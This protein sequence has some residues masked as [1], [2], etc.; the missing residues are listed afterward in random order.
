MAM[1]HLHKNPETAA[2]TIRI[3]VCDD[4]PLITEGLQS[5]IE[6]KKGFDVVA[7]ASSAASL[8][9]VLKIAEAD[10]LLLDINL[11]DGNGIDLCKDLKKQYP[12]LR[13]IGLSNFN[14]RSVI[15]RMIANGASGYLVKSSSLD[16]LLH[17]IEEVYAGNV[18]FGKEA[19]NILASL[20]SDTVQEL[21]PVTRREKEVLKWL[22]Q[23]LTSAEIGGKMFISPQTVDSHRKSLMQKFDVNK[24]VNLIQEAKRLGFV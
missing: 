24:T 11:P 14:E 10:V 7:T 12:Q 9:E 6:N 22:G 8:H 4:H 5:Y 17:G 1:N 20:A 18:Y 13:I 19:Q 2:E 16:T 21:P 15:T 3:V 23:G